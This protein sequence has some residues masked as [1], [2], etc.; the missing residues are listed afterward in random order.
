M[1][2]GIAKRVISPPAALESAEDAEMI[3]LFI[4]FGM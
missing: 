4:S 1:D 2:P 3:L